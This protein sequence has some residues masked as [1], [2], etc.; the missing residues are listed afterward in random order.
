[1][2]NI[3][4]YLKKIHEHN[5]NIQL[6]LD[7]EFFYHV[8]RI[9]VAGFQFVNFEGIEQKISSSGGAGGYDPSFQTF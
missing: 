9:F 6:K 1:M 5:M 3:N 2:G 4:K 7:P 8:L